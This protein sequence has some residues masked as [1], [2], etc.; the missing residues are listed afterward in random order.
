M[1]IKILAKDFQLQIAPSECLVGIGRDIPFQAIISHESMT[2]EPTAIWTCSRDGTDCSE[3]FANSSMLSQIISFTENGIYELKSEISI[4][5]VTKSATSKVTIDTK[6]IPHVQL[7]YFP[8]QPVDVTKPI[9]IVVTVLNLVPKCI[10]FWNVLSGDGLAGF[11]NG[12]EENLTNL[13]LIFIKDFEENFL[14]ELIDY[15][16]NTLSKDVILSIP[17]EVLLANEKYKFRL[18]TT[19]PEPLTDS[20]SQRGN[21]SSFYDI[22]F[23]T[24]APPE[25]FPL[26][27]APLN[28]IPMQQKF[29]FSTGA[30]KDSSTDFPLKYTFGYI[31]NNVTVIIG[32]FYES[33]VTHTRL[34]FA[35]AIET[36]CEVCDNNGACGR[37]SGPTVAANVSYNYSSEEIEFNLAEFQATLSRAEYSDSLNSA[38]VFLS[39]KSQWKAGIEQSSAYESKIFLM[40]YEELKKTKMTDSLGFV[41]QQNVIEFVKMS[42]I[43]MN[44]MPVYD[45]TFVED[46]LSLTETISRSSR[47][48][49]RTILAHDSYAKVVNHGNEYIKNVLSLSE[50]LLNSN[51]VT[52]V[53]REKGKF[54]SK[55]HRFIA[56]MCQDTNLNSQFIETK[57]VSFEVSK[58]F[59]PQLYLEEQKIPGGDDSTILFNHNGNFPSKYVCVAKV[60]FMMDMFSVD[61]NEHLVPI[62]E[63]LIL[64]N[65]GDTFKPIKAIEFSDG[66]TMEIDVLPDTLSMTCM[67]WNGEK[68]LTDECF[69]L[70]TN[71]TNQI[72][73][74]C[75]TSSVDG[76]VIK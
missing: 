46:L 18:T 48:M 49:K 60:K 29:K 41:Y 51:N 52:I 59:S 20:N 42:K 9:E 75:K 69:K 53:Q 73:C 17:K 27:V 13:G 65:N 1:P 6:V 74:K 68:W 57:L 2:A 26:I 15:D 21:I 45:E 70:K 37:I 28:G 43:V 4:Y 16:N 11:K 22:M 30:A 44:L 36:F 63:T 72:T 55:V 66:V 33:M 3:N 54:I 71:S 14:Q 23:E 7:K 35:D 56:S 31:F 61:T 25:L 34:P 32:S 12:S 62:Y 76:I 40:M 47:R 10:A 5:E 64:E 39:M 58:V 24:N 8:K 50:M 67:T 38:V 19:C